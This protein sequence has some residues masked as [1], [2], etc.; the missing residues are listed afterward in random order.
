MKTFSNILIVSRS[1]R[2]CA[3]VLRTGID[4]ARKY[5]AK[6]YILHIMYDPFN[7]D[8]WHLSAAA[9]DD[10]YKKTAAKAREELNH[11][12]QKEKA[13][14][15]VITEWIKDGFPADEIQKIVESEGVDLILML[16]HP[17]GRL[18]HLL[19]GKTNEAIIRKLPATLMLVK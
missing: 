4:M 11:I 14:G 8:G 10:E 13:E 7:I 17:E 2:H 19:F 18:E 12:I 6:L 9:I 16:A 5:N 3:K 1:T 15:L